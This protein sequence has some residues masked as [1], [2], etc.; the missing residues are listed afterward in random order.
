MFSLHKLAME[1]SWFTLGTDTPYHTLFE[2][3]QVSRM[4]YR[5][6]TLAPRTPEATT[7]L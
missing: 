7:K 4:P 2:S 1:I 3:K 6:F 5:T